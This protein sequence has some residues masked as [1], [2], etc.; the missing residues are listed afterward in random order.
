[1]TLAFIADVHLGNARWRG[2]VSMSGINRRC[3]YVLDVLARAVALANERGASGLVVLGDLFDTSRPTPQVITEAIKAFA[4][5]H[6]RVY[7]L[8]GN[9]DQESGD[10]GDNALG[11]LGFAPSLNVVER[12][13]VAWCGSA[14]LWLMPFRNGAASE[15]LPAALD[16]LATAAESAAERRSHALVARVLCLHL[17]IADDTTPPWLQGA[18]DAI[19][20]KELVALCKAHGIA[21]VF[22]GNWHERRSWV[23]DGVSVQQVGALAPTGFDN[24][25]LQGYGTVAVWRPGRVDCEELSGPRFVKVSTPGGWAS[26]L[27]ALRAER[28]GGG[29]VGAYPPVFVRREV[30]DAAELDEATA[31]MREETT[32]GMLAG[33]E[34]IPSTKAAEARTEEAVRVVKRSESL[35]QAVEGYV[36]GMGLPEASA[37]AVRELAM[38]YIGR[39]S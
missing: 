7:A 14:E 3:A 33:G 32:L 26:L 1:M 29:N 12:P 18:H 4:A 39:A 23:L 11:P 31:L 21:Q 34:V 16:T 15:W 22:C 6:G 19:H 2:G 25:G 5:A 28:T 35:A 17:G 20:V 8:V 9:H 10:D 27:S 38:A 13:T 24:P 36:A 37:R 30:G